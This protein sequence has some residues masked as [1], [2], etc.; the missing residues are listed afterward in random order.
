[1]ERRG[2]AGGW[3][4][5]VGAEVGCAIGPPVLRWQ[6]V[7]RSEKLRH[8]DERHLRIEVVDGGKL[9]QTRRVD[10]YCHRGV[11]QQQVFVGFGVCTAVVERRVSHRELKMSCDTVVM[12]LV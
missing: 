4:A 3:Q 2:A 5:A 11:R 7:E 10:P 9:A 1:M 8:R 6:F 12:V